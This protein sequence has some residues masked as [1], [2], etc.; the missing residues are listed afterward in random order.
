[1]Q[2]ILWAVQMEF[3]Q[4]AFHPPP[5]PLKQTDALWELFLPKISQFFKTASRQK[6]GWTSTLFRGGVPDSSDSRHFSRALWW[7]TDKSS[8]SRET[9]E[10]GKTGGNLITT[11]S[12]QIVLHLHWGRKLKCLPFFCRKCGDFI[13]CLDEGRSA[14]FT[15]SQNIAVNRLI[16]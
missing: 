4:I 1:M 8:D 3:C 6:S 11:F 16:G 15:E 7:K 14:D 13:F 10:F 9:D 5:F 2:Y 12:G